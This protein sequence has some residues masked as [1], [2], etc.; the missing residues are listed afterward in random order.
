MGKQV[1]RHLSERQDLLKRFDGKMEIVGVLAEQVRV[2]ELRGGRPLGID[3]LENRNEVHQTASEG[4]GRSQES[5]LLDS[6]G[7]LGRQ[8]ATHQSAHGQSCDQNLVA[9]PGS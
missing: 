4:K 8:N 2:G 5:Q 6:V 3:G 7:K 1:L 9:F